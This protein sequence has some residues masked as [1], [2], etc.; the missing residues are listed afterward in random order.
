VDREVSA[1]T[2][3]PL[4]PPHKGNAYHLH[5]SVSNPGALE[6]TAELDAKRGVLVTTDAALVGECDHFLLYL[7]GQTWT[8]G[9]QSDVLAAQVTRAICLGVHLLLAHEMRGLGGQ[10]ERYGCD[11]AL[12]FSNPDGSTPPA[13]LQRVVYNELAVPLKGGAWRD[14]SLA[15]LATALTTKDRDHAEGLSEESVSELSSLQA[16]AEHKL[17]AILDGVSALRS[18]SRP[19]LLQLVPRQARGDA[20]ARV[21]GVRVERR[22]SWYARLLVSKKGAGV[23]LAQPQPSAL[24]MSSSREPRGAANIAS[25]ADSTGWDSAELGQLALGSAPPNT[26]GVA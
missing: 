14:A 12:F 19:P 11:F 10:E 25:C 17:Q 13:L 8:R 18:S 2:V 7:N 4:P 3:R 6:L 21:E 1:L 22:P 20:A 5:C 9:A 16:A 15:L 23:E 26:D 24:S